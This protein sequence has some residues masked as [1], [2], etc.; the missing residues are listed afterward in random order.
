MKNFIKNIFSKK[1]STPSK[2]GNIY[3][4]NEWK[5]VKIKDSLKFKSYSNA[6]RKN[7]RDNAGK[8]VFVRRVAKV[9]YAIKGSKNLIFLLDFEILDDDE[10]LKQVKIF[11][12]TDTILTVGL[13]S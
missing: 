10:Y 11:S 1:S 5:R 13:S 2:K 8:I 12:N 4:N 9:F 6:D 3:K 7:L